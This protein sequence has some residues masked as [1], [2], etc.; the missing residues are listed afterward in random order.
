VARV[1]ERYPL[2]NALACPVRYESDG[3]SMLRAYRDM[4]ARGLDIVAVYHSHPA[5]EPVPSRTDLAC[6]YYP[7]VVHLIVSLATTPPRVRGW[8]LTE[9]DYREAEWEVVG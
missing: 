3:P 1:V 7:D 4:R 6:N 2:V 8:W 9:T 5:S